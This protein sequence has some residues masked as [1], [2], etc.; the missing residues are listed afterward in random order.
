MVKR[1]PTLGALVSTKTKCI[2]V[3]FIGKIKLVPVAFLMALSIITFYTKSHVLN[4][5]WLL[6][7]S[8]DLELGCLQKKHINVVSGLSETG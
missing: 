7:K 8:A 4:R 2:K 1:S 3:I 6:M 5:M